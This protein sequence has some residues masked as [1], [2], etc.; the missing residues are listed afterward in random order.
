MDQAE[1][2][3]PETDRLFQSCAAVLATDAAWRR[4]L[5]R[6]LSTPGLSGRTGA[7]VIAFIADGHLVRGA[8]ALAQVRAG[9]GEAS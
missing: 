8:D 6:E 4:T 2:P 5:Q 3:E 7:E 1:A 9:E